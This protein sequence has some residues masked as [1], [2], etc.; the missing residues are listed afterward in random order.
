MVG[1]RRARFCRG[2]RGHRLGRAFPCVLALRYALL[3][4]ALMAQYAGISIN[5]LVMYAGS[6][7]CSSWGAMFGVIYMRT[8]AMVL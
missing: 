2:S 5:G 1:R 8:A 7:C 3:I 6:L 4:V